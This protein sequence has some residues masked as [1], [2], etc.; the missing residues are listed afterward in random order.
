MIHTREDTLERRKVRTWNA[1]KASSEDA[2][3]ESW[4]G[5]LT[6]G[7]HIVLNAMNRQ[8]A[9]MLRVGFLS[10]CA[11]KAIALIIHDLGGVAARETHGELLDL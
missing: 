9:R 3:E 1:K 2:L 6:P 10:S 11:I 5:V 7:S 8:E 4:H